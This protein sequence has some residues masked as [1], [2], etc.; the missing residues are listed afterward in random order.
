MSSENPVL[1]FLVLLDR[2]RSGIAKEKDSKNGEL[3]SLHLALDQID[4]R[5]PGVVK[6]KKG[7][8]RERLTFQSLRQ[9]LKDA[10]QAPKGT[11]LT[12]DVDALPSQPD[13]VNVGEYM[14]VLEEEIEALD[15]QLWEHPLMVAA[16]WVMKRAGLP[17]EEVVDTAA[18]YD[19]SEFALAA[20]KQRGRPAK[21]EFTE[22]YRDEDTM[23]LEFVPYAQEVIAEE[24]KDLHHVPPK[25]RE[26][27]YT[28]LDRHVCELYPWIRDLEGYTSPETTPS[29]HRRALPTSWYV[30]Y[31]PIQSSGFR[32]N[33]RRHGLKPVPG[34]SRGQSQ[35]WYYDEVKKVA[36]EQWPRKQLPPPPEIP[37]RESA[38]N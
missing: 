38:S 5:L 24:L 11:E 33:M 23:I 31:L 20:R 4:R 32:K 3:H 34:T 21:F 29:P 10:R 35:E 27:D 1:D 6:T 18:R 22:K 17:Y 13:E 16:I 26:L 37:T 25:L 30:K 8:L 28:E 12:Y 2:H 15:D 7:T 36:N 9:A 14:S 19:G